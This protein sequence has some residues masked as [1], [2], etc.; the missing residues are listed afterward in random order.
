MQYRN[1]FN[2]IN[3]TR[4]HLLEFQKLGRYTEISRSLSVIWTVDVST[5][6]IDIYLHGNTSAHHDI[7]LGYEFVGFSEEGI[8][9]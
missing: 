1:D 9:F 6:E 4:R 8:R 7:S 5:K 2:R 3:S